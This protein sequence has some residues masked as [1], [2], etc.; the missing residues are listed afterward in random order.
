MASVFEIFTPEPYTFLI[1]SQDIE[2]NVISS[3]TGA[4]GVFKLRE[5]MN[6]A[7]AIET[8]TADA[9]LRIKPSESFVDALEDY[10][11]GHGV[12]VGRGGNTPSTYRIIGQTEGYD[13]DTQTLDFYLLQ[14]KAERFA[15]WEESEL[16]LE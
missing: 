9:T 3:T 7:E 14:L 8:P 15:E 11:I 6:S 2:G 10:L 13:Y 5:G 1:I 4:K 16:P 12:S